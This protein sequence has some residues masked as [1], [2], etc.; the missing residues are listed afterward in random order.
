[1]QTYRTTV[2]YH[3]TTGLPKDDVVNTFHFRTIE[4][5]PDPVTATQLNGWL[6]ARLEGAAAVN[7]D[8][9]HLYMSNEIS[10]VT[11]PTLRTYDVAG[12]SP[13]A[14]DTMLAM[15]GALGAGL[16]S[17]AAVCLSFHS[18]LTG[19]LEFAPDGADADLAP[20]RPRARHRNRIYFGPLV[21]GAATGSPARPVAQVVQALQDLATDLGNPADTT[22][23]NGLLPVWV[24]YSEKT[25][26]AFP[27]TGCWVD[28]SFD[29]QRRRGVAPTVR[30]ALA[31]G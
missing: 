19:I 8:K 26:E 4:D 18:D 25:G 5:D 1:M 17:E 12:G 27:V 10:R 14:V 3:R 29:T 23:A 28:D 30:N 21:L 20:D 24:T 7:G 6:S 31:V 9:L 22:L 11:K 16:P 15:T 13:L 2:T